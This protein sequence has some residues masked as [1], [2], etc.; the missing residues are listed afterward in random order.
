M[1]K[2]YATGEHFGAAKAAMVLKTLLRLARHGL[3][4]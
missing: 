3:L 2:A 1:E 4:S